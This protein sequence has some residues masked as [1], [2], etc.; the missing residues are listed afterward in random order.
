MHSTCTE[1]APISLFIKKI[2]N[3]ILNNYTCTYVHDDMLQIS[4]RYKV[5]VHVN[6]RS[7]CKGYSITCYSITYDANIKKS[8][9]YN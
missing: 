4:M 8:N 3:R 7:E 6:G 5:H 1:H 2:N 9:V